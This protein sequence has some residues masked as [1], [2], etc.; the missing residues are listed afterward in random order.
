MAKKIIDV[1]YTFTPATKTIV[2]N[3]AIKQENLLLI[4]N[5]T[6]NT[7]IYNFS[8]PSLGAT[9]V[10]PSGTQAAAQTTIV[11]SF[12]TAAMSA[13]DKIQVLYEDSVETFVPGDVFT[14]PVQ[15]LRVSEPQALIDTDFEYS[16]QPTKW[17]FL[18]LVQYRSSFYSKGTGGNS[19]IITAISGGGQSPRSTIT[20]T[21]ANSFAVGDIVTVQETTNQLAD[22]T[23][24][25]T[26]A[27]GTSFTYICKGV[28]SGSVYDANSTI[29]YGGGLFDGA[30]IPM[31]AASSSGAT[32]SV[33]TVTCTNPHGLLPGSPIQIVNATSTG[34]NGFWIIT[35]VP[36]PTT[37]TFTAAGLVTAGAQTL[38]SA[39][40]TVSPEA[41]VQHRSTDGGVSITP[42]GN[43]VGVQAIRQTRRYFRYQSGKGIQFSTGAKF[44]PTHDIDSITASGATATVTTMQDH[45]FQVGAT[46]LVDGVTVRTGTN[47]YN[48]S[49]TIASVTGTKT[50]TYTMSGTPTD[51]TPSG[52][53]YVTATGWRGATTR[54]GLFDDQNGF[55][56]EYDG[57]TL[58]ACRR[59]GIK[60]LAGK[61]ATT[62]NGN[63]ITGTSTRFRSQLLVGDRVIIKGTTY[64]V[65]QI[66][67]DT[68]LR[69]APAYRGP[70]LSL[71]RM[72]KVENIRV[73]QSQW[74]GDKMDGT[75]PSGYNIDISKMQMAYIDYTWYGAGH[76]RFGFR[77][78]NGDIVYCHR[79]P[80]NNTN[81]A[82][83][84]RSGNLPA[85][86][87]IENYGYYTRLVAG[88]AGTKGSA[89]GTSDTTLY[90]EDASLF[91]TPSAGL[92][93]AVLLRDATNC[94]LVTYTGIGAYN[95]TAGGYPLTGCTRRTTISIAGV[96]SVGS[97]NAA[98]YVLGGTTSSVTFTPDASL[99]GA[100]T[101]QVSVQEI[102]NLVA[103]IVSHWG[104][105]VI[106]DGRYDNDKEIRF[107]AGMLKYMNIAAGAQRPLM[108]IRI[109]PSVDSGNGRNFGI[110]DL[111]NRMQ[112]TL[113]A[114]G[115]Y[116]QGQFLIEGILNPFTISGGSWSNATSWTT[117]P[118]GSGS[119][120]QVFY[121]DG[122]GVAG[123]QATAS[124]TFT[125]GDRIFGAYTENSGGTN[126]STTRIELDEIRDLGTSILSGDGSTTNWAYPNAP[127]VLLISARNLGA[128]ATNIAA[129]I[130]W[131]EA[132]A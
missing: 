94:E 23:Y 110:R 77:A 82:A 3:R 8:D 83:Y 54:I 87:E 104:V 7:V 62:L 15:K 78:T 75:G 92:P 10:T 109:A 122:T 47:T 60:E 101:A 11:L 68:S 107:T 124:G 116:S 103:P 81:Y 21:A 4:T 126:Y 65:T 55:F 79:M 123:A 67:S 49:F 41:Y 38:G 25:V 114:L 48:G 106:M 59:Q 22:G 111:V 12:N 6:T 127:D 73:P 39:R 85:R 113:R 28:V 46:I 93:G 131:T 50:F 105:S 16:T 31:S 119:L 9:S 34:I 88:A 91:P 51:T 84:Q 36:S 95:A 118:V 35:T 132:Q 69:I 14:D 37:F 74:N 63:T 19:L 86:F 29:A 130:S 112:L 42:G 26:S 72:L 43:Y 17:E 89:L 121:F 32:P 108:M 27:N 96:N 52:Y 45:N 58:F 64:E 97:W 53:S 80:N 30:A 98:A 102:R 61:V 18:P 24:A 5:V 57:K 33:I 40:L 99:G 100:G 76:I 117:V 66:D 20:V 120:A 13:N 1:G 90:V 70:T 44:T 115:V 2:V 71:A 125:G 129:R 128:T 56:F